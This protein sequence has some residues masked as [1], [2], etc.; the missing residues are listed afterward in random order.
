MPTYALEGVAV[1]FPYEAYDCQV[2]AFYLTHI[3]TRAP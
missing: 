3:S 1:D 2:I